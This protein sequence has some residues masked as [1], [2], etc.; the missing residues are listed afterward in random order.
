MEAFFARARSVAE[1]AAKKTQEITVK[2]SQDIVKET[3]KVSSQLVTE[4]AK[5]SEQLS[6]NPT[7]QDIASRSKTFAHEAGKKAQELAKEAAEKIPALAQQ[8]AQSAGEG[9]QSLVKELKV[10]GSGHQPLDQELEEYGVTEDLREFVRGMT[11]DTFKEFPVD[12][13]IK[14]LKEAATA[15]EGVGAVAA[16]TTENALKTDQVEV[17]PDNVRHDLNAFQTRHAMLVLESVKEISTFRYQLCPRVMPEHR[18][19]KI[20]FMLVH[21]H[22]LPYETRWSERQQELA[23]G[24]AAFKEQAAQAAAIATT[25]PAAKA[26]ASDSN[27]S[28]NKSTGSSGTGAK[29]AVAAA[30]AAAAAAV[31]TTSTSEDLDDKK[32]EGDDI[33][34]LLM[35]ALGGDDAGDDDE[36]DGAFDAEDFDE[37]V[38]SAVG[39]DLD[40]IK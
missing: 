24:F 34:A 4:T 30:G 13:E 14:Q 25:P 18:F 11:L 9:I 40:D 37:L 5:Y 23:A 17:G 35:D 31:A 26:L 32:T 39:S 12:D 19:W 22:V 16:T 28:L 38:K 2:L 27:S 8:T 29:T 20:Y 6:K 33:D 3:T 1:E 36:D 10:G 7:I 21:T 15:E